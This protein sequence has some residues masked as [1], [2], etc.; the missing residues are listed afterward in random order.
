[1]P[2][3]FF[4]PPF[5]AKQVFL[6]ITVIGDGLLDPLYSSSLFGPTGTAQP[7]TI[8]LLGGLLIEIA[9]A[10]GFIVIGIIIFQ[11]KTKF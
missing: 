5:W 2:I 11:K 8:T 10:V 9:F 3:V 6:Q 7:L 1:S 4:T